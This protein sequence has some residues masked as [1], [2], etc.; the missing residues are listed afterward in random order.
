MSDDGT[1]LYALEADRVEGFAVQQ[2]AA[3]ESTAASATRTIPLAGS[4]AP[5]AIVAVPGAKPYLGGPG[6]D[7]Q[8]GMP[9]ASA[10]NPAPGGGTRGK[11]PRTDTVLDDAARWIDGRQV[12]PQAL[13]V[14]MV[15]LVLGLFAIRWYER[16]GEARRGDRS[17]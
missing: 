9:A 12:L 6:T 8:S 5:L 13:L 2:P 10:A 14:G 16:S 1:F 15:I 11:P 3:D 4:R 7:V 17:P